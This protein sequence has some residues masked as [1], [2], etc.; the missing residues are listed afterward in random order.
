MLHV[1]SKHSY[2]NITY[3]ILMML[4][5]FSKHSYI[6]LHLLWLNEL[7]S[8]SR[9]SAGKGQNV[10]RRFHSQNF[11]N[12]MYLL[13]KKKKR[14]KKKKLFCVPFSEQIFTGRQQ[15]LFNV[16]LHEPNKPPPPPEKK[17]R[18]VNLTHERTFVKPSSSVTKKEFHH[19]DKEVHKV[20]KDR[21]ESPSPL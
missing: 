18:N 21:H 13:T 2:K 11:S 20:C 3:S 17:R 8:L 7:N 16:I 5:V 12:V 1:F 14:K 4:H 10:G 19:K 9:K 6:L 15:L